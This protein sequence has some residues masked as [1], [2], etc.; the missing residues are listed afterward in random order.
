M[1]DAP[2]LRDECTRAL[3]QLP[4]SIECAALEAFADA[5]TNVIAATY[6]NDEQG[7][8]SKATQIEDALES[9]AVNDGFN[10]VRSDFSGMPND[11]LAVLLFE[12]RYIMRRR[13]TRRNVSLVALAYAY[14]ATQRSATDSAQIWYLALALLVPR[15]LL[16]QLDEGAILT[17]NS[18]GKLTGWALPF[19]VLEIRAELLR[20]VLGQAA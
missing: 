13:T 7:L 12:Q 15:S 6:A 10:V 18:L 16:D 19:W 5:V 1:T 8:R 2:M 4:S 17:A 14:A 9:A 20:R 3:E 11:L